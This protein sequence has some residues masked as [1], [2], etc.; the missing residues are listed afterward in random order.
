MTVSQDWRTSGVAVDTAAEIIGLVASTCRRAEVS[1]AGRMP[2]AQ[3]CEL[4]KVVFLGTFDKVIRKLQSTNESHEDEE[5]AAL[6]ESLNET[7]DPLVEA[8][9]ADKT[10]VLTWVRS[11][12]AQ[13]FQ[14]NIA[15]HV[16]A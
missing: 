5:V 11:Q 10:E 16:P 8:T 9:G 13:A 2:R 14:R 4:A 6:M 3:A 7:I 1:A 15:E 12:F